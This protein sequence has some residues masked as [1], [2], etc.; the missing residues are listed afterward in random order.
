[1]TSI[2][3]VSR[4]VQQ[5]L[6]EVANRAAAASGFTKRPSKLSGA[7][8]VR[9]LV[10]GWLAN[11]EAT[12]NELSQTSALVGTPVSAA[13]LEQ[14]FSEAGAECLRQVLVAAVQVVVRGRRWRCRCWIASRP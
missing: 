4:A 6:T 7:S 14:R 13:A 11:P 2:P 1:M 5:L 12:M 3:Q 8:F 9:T 10:F